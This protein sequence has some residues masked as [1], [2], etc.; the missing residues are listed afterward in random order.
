MGIRR[1]IPNVQ[2][3]D[4]ASTAAFYRDFVG[5][6]TDMEMPEDDFVMMSSP[7]VTSAQI[8]IND[9]GFRGLPPGFAVD[10]G[11]AEEVTALHGRAVAGRLRVVEPLADK[12][13][14]IRRFSVLDPAGT[15]VTIIGHL[16]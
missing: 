2:A 10:V 7:D 13:W 3:A 14:G 16:A 8:T 15:R 9:N 6:V 4:V 5:L 1:I 12:P 11:S